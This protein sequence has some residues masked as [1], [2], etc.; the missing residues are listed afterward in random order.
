MALLPHK[1]SSPL[2]TKTTFL[3]NKFNMTYSTLKPKIMTALSVSA[4]I[5]SHTSN[6]A[7]AADDVTVSSNL[8]KNKNMRQEKSLL[9]GGGLI[10]P[11]PTPPSSTKCYFEGKQY[12]VGQDVYCWDCAYDYCTCLASGSWGNCRNEEASTPS[13]PWENSNPNPPPPP[14]TPTPPMQPA[15]VWPSPTPPSSTKCYFEGKQYNVGQDVY[16]WDCAYDYCTCLASGSW[17]NCRN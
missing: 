13:P 8:R 7:A 14:P 9:P 15:P 12:N 16:C 17:G 6:S 3:N 10:W 11:S 4:L 2:S 5:L 1:K